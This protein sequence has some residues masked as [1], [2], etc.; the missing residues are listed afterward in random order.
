MNRFSFGT[1]FAIIA[2]IILVG[3]V[4]YRAALVYDLLPEKYRPEGVAKEQYEEFK[5][6]LLER[7]IKQ[8]AMG[9]LSKI[10]LDVIIN[11]ERYYINWK[12]KRD[13]KARRELECEDESAYK[14]FMGWGKDEERIKQ[15]CIPKK[16]KTLPED[17]AVN[18]E[19]TN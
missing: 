16:R 12:K 11:V 13:E 15:E 19:A 9:K 5:T 10:S 4:L 7:S 2:G 3:I 17:Q 1:I 14:F 8:D 6:V 18:Q